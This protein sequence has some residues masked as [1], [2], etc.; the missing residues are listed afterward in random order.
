MD[1]LTALEKEIVIMVAQGS[2]NR[3]IAEKLCLAEQTVRNYLS[4]IYAKTDSKNRVELTM[5]A[6]RAEWINSTREK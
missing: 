2:K 1:T 5:F 3:E 4:N 6:V